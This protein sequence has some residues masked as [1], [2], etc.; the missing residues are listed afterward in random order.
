MVTNEFVQ[1]ILFF[2]AVETFIKKM[3]LQI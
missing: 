3:K 1:F 2:S